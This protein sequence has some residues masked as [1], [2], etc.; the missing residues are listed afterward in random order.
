[1]AFCSSCGTELTGAFCTKCG[2][3][4]GA[5]QAQ[6]SGTPAMSPATTPARVPVRRTSPIVW[7]LVAILGI[8]VLCGI[9]AAGV[10]FLVLHRARQ[11]GVIFDHN[12]NGGFEIRGRDG[13]V[14]FGM[15]GKVPSWIPSYPGSRP[16]FAVRAEGKEA[17]RLQAGP[18]VDPG[19]GCIRLKPGKAVK[20][21]LIMNE[22][23]RGPFTVSALDPVTQE[24]FAR[25]DLETDY[26]E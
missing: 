11:A 23:H 22:D 21:T 16:T 10:G 12:R 14:A 26:T 2:R 3:P 8:I 19:S 7:V 9:G 6:P 5:A 25:L 4:V 17:G 15:A 13:T 24:Q 1:M 20:M 18:A